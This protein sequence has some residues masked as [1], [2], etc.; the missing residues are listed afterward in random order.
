M[1]QLSELLES[2]SSFGAAFF[3]PE[4]NAVNASHLLIP[5]LR[6]YTYARCIDTAPFFLV[7]RPL[8]ALLVSLMLIS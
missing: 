3:S 4:H 1:A 5:H 6:R 8:T 2:W 7:F